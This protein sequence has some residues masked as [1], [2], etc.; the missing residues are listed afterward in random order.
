MT[1]SVELTETN[2]VLSDKPIRPTYYSLYRKKLIA[3]R[4]NTSQ[5]A[6]KLEAKEAKLAE[7]DLEKQAK[8]QTDK[9][10]KVLKRNE[11]KKDKITLDMITKKNA[12]L[13]VND[14]STFLSKNVQN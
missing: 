10:E 8:H 7:K 6:K 11:H 4:A 14:W 12:A 5:D 3:L 2:K 9:M 1:D 13:S